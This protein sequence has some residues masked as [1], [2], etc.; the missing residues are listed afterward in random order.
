MLRIDPAGATPPYEQL[1]S[2]LIQ[3]IESGEL[4]PGSRLPAVRRLASDL[5]IAPNTVAR[6]YRELETQGYVKT[7]GRRGTIVSED[8]SAAPA[9]TATR[10]FAR[11]L[12]DMGIDAE[13]AVRMLRRAFAEVA[14]R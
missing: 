1:R 13:S 5:G 3:Q 12:V 7:A 4:P 9:L 6:T 14:Q 11:Q 8:T 10:D 2:Q